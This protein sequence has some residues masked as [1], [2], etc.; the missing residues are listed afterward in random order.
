MSR[1]GWQF[2]DP[3]TD[4]VYVW[5]VNPHTDSGSHAIE[6]NV[7]WD[8]RAGSHRTAAG[9]HQ[10]STIVFSKGRNLERFS[11]SG[12]VYDQDQ[13]E[14]MNEWIS[15]DYAIEM[16]DDLGRVFVILVEEFST[17][18]VRSR[19]SP[20]KHEYNFSGIVLDRI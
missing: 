5:P 2:I 20:W 19:Q 9:A 15:K 1:R 11:Y 16:V 18:R 14:A 12:F 10:I 7:E 8:V 17:S 3:L 13:L 4:E 6:K